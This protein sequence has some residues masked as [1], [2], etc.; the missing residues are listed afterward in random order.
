MPCTGQGTGD[1]VHCGAEDSKAG[2]DSNLLKDSQPAAVG[3]GP[4]GFPVGAA[5]REG[6]REQPGF[7][8]PCSLQSMATCSSS[9]LAGTDLFPTSLSR[10]PWFTLQDLQDALPF[11][12]GGSVLNATKWLFQTPSNCTKTARFISALAL[13]ISS[14]P[15]GFS[16][17]CCS[18][19]T[20][21]S[22]LSPPAAHGTG[23]VYTRISPHC[24]HSLSKQQPRG[25]GKCVW[26]LARDHRRTRTSWQRRQGRS[27]VK[28]Y[29]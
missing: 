20:R 26:E 1:H 25:N 21:Q 24:T 14:S 4:V 12:A 19:S 2:K 3:Q 5:G 15:S 17:S 27:V 29:L 11:S 9:V 16:I 6:G 18:Y 28:L 7:Q 10:I 23:L 13:S 22:C 8:E